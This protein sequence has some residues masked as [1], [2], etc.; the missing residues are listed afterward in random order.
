MAEQ[1][2]IIERIAKLLALGNSAN[3]NE[4]AIAIERAQRL[5]AE[6]KI[7]M[8]D[9]TMN[10]I[11][12]VEQKL[13]TIL[14]DRFLFTTLGNLVARAFGVK[15]FYTKMGSVTKSVT[16]IGPNDRVQSAG[17]TFTVIA[18]QAAIAKKNFTAAKKEEIEDS[19]KKE[20]SFILSCLPDGEDTSFKEFA[21]YFPNINSIYK[22][23]LRSTTKAYLQGWLYAI[24]EKVIDF[25]MDDQEELLIEQFMHEKHGDLSPM[26][27]ARSRYLSSSELA[28]YRNGKKDGA[29]GFSLFHGVG[30]EGAIRA[31]IGHNR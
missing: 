12:E 22:R 26:R 8:S 15:H 25:A 27:R 14:R 18:R 28:A 13:P 21:E 20:Y 2:K 7:S 10:S 1:D 3:P 29:E 5:M 31:A 16:F 24:N 4:A 30:G 19:L 11:S 9:I 17:Y 6:H 23:Q